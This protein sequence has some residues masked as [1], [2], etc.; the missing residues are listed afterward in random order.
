[1]SAS[2][3]AAAV[4]GTASGTYAA[5]IRSPT[6][7]TTTSTASGGIPTVSPITFGWIR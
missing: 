6:P 7:V 3:A 2:V 1:M 5:P 4:K